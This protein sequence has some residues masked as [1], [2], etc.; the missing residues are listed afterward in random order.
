MS[1]MID[2]MIKT[3]QEMNTPSEDPEIMSDYV[4]EEQKIE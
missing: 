2:K 1:D 4:D 3:N